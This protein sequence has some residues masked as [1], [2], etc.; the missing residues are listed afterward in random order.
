MHAAPVVEHTDTTGSHRRTSLGCL[1]V[2]SASCHR[3]A[4]PST[5]CGSPRPRRLA[6]NNTSSR[7]LPPE[8][9]VNAVV[10]SRRRQLPC[11]QNMGGKTVYLMQR[12]GIPHTPG[13]SQMT[14]CLYPREL[15]RNIP[16]KFTFTVFM[17]DEGSPGDRYSIINRIQNKMTTLNRSNLGR[18]DIYRM[19]V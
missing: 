2:R 8:P 14:I 3:Q 17:V 16:Q 7:R 6:D 13:T 19:S 9:N 4:L 18:L 12:Y 1:P 11:E 5:R 15:G 10:L